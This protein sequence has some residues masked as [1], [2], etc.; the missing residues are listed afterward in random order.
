MEFPTTEMNFQF[1]KESKRKHVRIEFLTSVL[2]SHQCQ[3]QFHLKQ[4]SLA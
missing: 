3:K 1:K 2:N 4:F